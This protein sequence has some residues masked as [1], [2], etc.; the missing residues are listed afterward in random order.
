MNIDK[1]IL[2][3]LNKTAELEEFEML[4][5]WKKE[6]A[7]NI[8]YLNMMSQKYDKPGYQDFDKEAAWQKVEKEI[9]STSKTKWIV[10]GLLV[11]IVA[12]TYLMFNNKDTAEEKKEFKTKTEMEHFVLAD[13]SKIWL[14]SNS[15]VLA[16]SDFKSERKVK[17]T[18]EAYFEVESDKTNP[19]VIMLNESD[20]VRVVGTS[21]NILNEAS[22]FEL[23]VYSGKVELHVLNRVIQLG[24][25][26]RVTK[27]NETFAKTKSTDK[28]V[29][30]WKTKELIFENTPLKKVLNQI[31]DQYNVDISIDENLDFSKC[32]LRSIYKDFS[33]EQVM[34]ELEEI[35]KL[36]YT[37]EGNSIKVNHV[38]CK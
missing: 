6:S 23:N 16:M 20:Y 3:V 14:N 13:D 32:Y 2:K 30:S 5:A 22:E 27:I 28:N 25:G 37:R 35:F 9:S 31:S 34:S 17:L 11:L 24:K 10:L 18:G 4:E 26:D 7:D 15:E 1:I 33:L 21:F 8:D 38:N 29:L 12:A 19:F 36:E